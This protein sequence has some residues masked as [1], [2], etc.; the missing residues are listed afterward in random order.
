MYV[1]GT[2]YIAV[3]TIVVLLLIIIIILI[4][5]GLV[6][7]NKKKKIF[8]SNVPIS[9]AYPNPVYYDNKSKFVMKEVYWIN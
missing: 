4:V 8:A 9:A 6:R 5:V 3:A 7:K 1:P 2:V